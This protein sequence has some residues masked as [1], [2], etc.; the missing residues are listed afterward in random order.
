MI[1]MM[2]A[3]CVAA[4]MMVAVPAVTFASPDLQPC[5]DGGDAAKAEAEA[6]PKARGNAPKKED[7]V[8]P[9]GDK[10]RE[11]AKKGDRKE[12]D[13]EDEDTP[14]EEELE[15]LRSLGYVE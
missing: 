11:A 14:S 8:A 2:T 7:A 6:Q 4:L 15:Q 5:Q 9:D 10:K 12:G 1:R 13:S 3:W